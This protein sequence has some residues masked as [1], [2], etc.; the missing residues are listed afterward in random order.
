MVS[1]VAE[2][3]I[4]REGSVLW[5]TLSRPDVLNAL[6]GTMNAGLAVALE[7][8]R[9]PVVRA[10]VLSGAGR[11]FCAGG[12]LV[13]LSSGVQASPNDCA[14]RRTATCSRSA[15]LRSP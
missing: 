9:D 1:V 2:V 14:S 5:I 11:G 15:R 8:A 7:E 12:D 3:E 6:N 13:E 4:R 10:V